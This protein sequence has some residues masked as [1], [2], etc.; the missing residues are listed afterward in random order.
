M[1]DQLNLS[2][3]GKGNWLYALIENDRGYSVASLERRARMVE[4]DGVNWI[5]PDLHAIDARDH[6]TTDEQWQGIINLVAAAPEMLAVLKRAA[7]ESWG[8]MATV[9]RW[10]ADVRAVLAKAEPPRT[11]KHTLWVTVKVEIEADTGT[12]DEVIRRRASESVYT[13]TSPGVTFK[14]KQVAGRRELYEE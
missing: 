13:S 5:N 8:D 12:S 9:E 2:V 7:D 3:P 1:A 11:A 14:E 4:G 6:A 10:L